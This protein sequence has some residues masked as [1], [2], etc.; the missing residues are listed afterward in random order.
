MHGHGLCCHQGPV[1]GVHEQECAKALALQPAIHGKAAE[2]DAGYWVVRQ[3]FGLFFRE[4]VAPEAGGAEAVVAA[5]EGLVRPD[6]HED[7][8]HVPFDVQSSLLT[9]VAVEFWRAR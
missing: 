3:A 6:G 2:E 9:D 5:D 8:G 4:L 7:T 1:H